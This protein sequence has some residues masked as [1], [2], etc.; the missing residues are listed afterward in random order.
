M[1]ITLEGPEGSGKTTAVEAA[2]KALEEKGYQIVRTREPGV[3]HQRPVRGAE[4]HDHEGRAER[5]EVD[6]AQRQAD[7]R[8]EAL[9]PPL[10]RQ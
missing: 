2:V 6:H 4:I 9:F 7:C 10:Y 3:V 8:L 1:F 5:G